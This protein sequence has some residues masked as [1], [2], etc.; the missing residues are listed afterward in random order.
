MSTFAAISGPSIVIT[1]ASLATVSPLVTL[2][3]EIT[4]FD[5]AARTE[6]LSAA[7][8][9]EMLIWRE[10]SAKAGVMTAT[11]RSAGAAAASVRTGIAAWASSLPTDE[12]LPVMTQAPAPI[13]TRIAA[14]RWARK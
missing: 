4:P 1:T 2:S 12:N 7:V 14:A 6:V 10:W 11:V 13:S 5:R 3:A 8:A 9:P